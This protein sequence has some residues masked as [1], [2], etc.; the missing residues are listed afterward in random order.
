MRN[1]AKCK[2]VFSV[3]SV[4]LDQDT[5]QSHILVTFLG[6]WLD[7]LHFLM[8]IMSECNVDDCVCIILCEL[9]SLLRIQFSTTTDAE[10]FQK[11]FIL[12]HKKFATL[13][14]WQIRSASDFLDEASRKTKAANPKRPLPEQQTTPGIIN[15][16]I[17]IIILIV[18]FTEFE[19]IEISSN[20]EPIRDSETKIETCK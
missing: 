8:Q 4:S 11:D 10:S 2:F 18:L 6:L 20:S 12:K 14:S 16:V 5:M 13:S 1:R 15:I 9:T 3:S 7:A 19:L 17:V